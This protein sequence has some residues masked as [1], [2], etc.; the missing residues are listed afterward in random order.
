MPRIVCDTPSPDKPI[1]KCLALGTSYELLLEAPDFDV[2]SLPG[3]VNPRRVV[4]GMVE[5][6]T[7]IVVANNTA[8]TET[9]S[10][11]IIR[12]DGSTFVIAEQIPVPARDQIRIPVQGQFLLKFDAAASNGD[13]LEI[14]SSASANVVA[15]ISAIEKEASDHIPEVEV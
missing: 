15:T 9:V 6:I 12:E 11:R 7:P 4:P 13:R 2:P 10:A 1:G 3:D 8:A 5:I 14:R